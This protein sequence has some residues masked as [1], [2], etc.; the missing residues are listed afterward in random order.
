MQ[1]WQVHR[2]L[3]ASRR[4][5]RLRQV[6]QLHAPGRAA[7]R[8]RG[9]RGAHRLAPPPRPAP[10]GGGA[11]GRGQHGEA[12]AGGEAA[13]Q[14][15]RAGGGGRGGGGGRRAGAGGPAP[16]VVLAPGA[17]G[18]GPAAPAPPVHAPLLGLQAAPGLERLPRHLLA[19][20]SALG[21][22][23]VTGSSLSRQCRSR[24]TSFSFCHHIMRWKFYSFHINCGCF[25]YLLLFFKISL[26][27][28]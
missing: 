9:G 12:A 26:S 27:Y 23:R 15:A 25:Y 1:D 8:V 16:A 28:G 10:H 7:Q 6:V 11:V 14:A 19:G 2:R 22:R 20:A 3:G 5:A 13:R 21:G 4:A 18:A 17:V 24:L